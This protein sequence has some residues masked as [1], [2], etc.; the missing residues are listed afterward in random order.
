[1]KKLVIIAHLLVWTAALPTAAQTAR[2]A[3][4]SHSGSAATLATEEGADNFGIPSPYFNADSIRLLSDTVAL[5]YGKWVDFQFHDNSAAS[6]AYYS[7]KT[8][9]L[10]LGH[11][12][13][14]NRGEI[15]RYYRRYHPEIKLIDFDTTQVPVNALPPA[16]VKQK[17][18]RRKAGA[19]IIPTIPARPDGVTLAVAG[20][21]ALSGAG[22]L[23]GERR[24]TQTPAA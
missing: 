12:D 15:V 10:R 7:R 21:L 22:W 1:M 23:L 3:H 14:K 11:Y 19:F 4:F 13:F 5:A 6:K 24:P 17:T 2:M 16:K 18:K 8:D 9:T 20:I